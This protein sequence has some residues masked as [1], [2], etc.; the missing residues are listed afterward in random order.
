[1][2][3]LKIRTAALRIAHGSTSAVTHAGVRDAK[4]ARC[5]LQNRTIA[6]LCSTIIR[7]ATWSLEPPIL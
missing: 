7:S 2:M 3:R 4:K 6:R 5:F 1:M